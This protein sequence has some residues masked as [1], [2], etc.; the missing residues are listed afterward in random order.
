MKFEVLFDHTYN[1]VALSEQ[2]LSSTRVEIMYFHDKL[3]IA[4][5]V[6]E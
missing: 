3:S 6:S 4:S 2:L 1:H 5:V